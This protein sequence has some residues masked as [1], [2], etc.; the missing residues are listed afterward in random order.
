M[1]AIIERVKSGLHVVGSGRLDGDE[2]SVGARWSAPWC[3]PRRWH[4]QRL[5]CESAALVEVGD[6]EWNGEHSRFYYWAVQAP[7]G[8][9]YVHLPRLDMGGSF[10]ES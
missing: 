9:T 7:G 3:S 6:A 10:L 5:L 4:S 8:L 1:A 2:T